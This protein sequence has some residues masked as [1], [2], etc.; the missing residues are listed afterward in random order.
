MGTGGEGTH[1]KI[2]TCPCPMGEWEGVKAQA[3]K[4]GRGWGKG[5]KAINVCKVGAVEVVVVVVCRCMRTGDW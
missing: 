4:L 2:Q 3:G 1:A 5:H